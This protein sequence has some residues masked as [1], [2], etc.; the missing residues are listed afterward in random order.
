MSEVAAQILEKSATPPATVDEQVSGASTDAN[1]APAGARPDDK[2]ASKIEVLIRREQMARQR[3]LAAQQKEA[4]LEA[5]LKA[6]EDRFK[7]VDEF[8]SIKTKNPLQALEKLGLTYEDL[9]KIQLSDGEVPPDVQIKKIEE[10]FSQFETAREQ[11]KAQQAETAKKAAAD[12]EEQAIS[13]FKGEIGTY[14]DDNKARYELISF[15]SQQ[16]LVFQVIDEHYRRTIDPETGVGKVMKIEEAA[17]KVEQ[18][19]E[20]KEIKRR[21]V[22]KVKA[23]WS[24]VPKDAIKDAAKQINKPVQQPRTLTNNLSAN[25]TARKSTAPITDQ[26]RVQRAIAYAREKGLA[27]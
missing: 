20:E 13:S 25:Q 3:E 22:S 15:E 8:E 18:F 21:S 1:P 24:A 2:V 14:L 19:L 17:D 7:K 16:D 5:K 10:K 12:R 23:L 11:E 26:E 4:D 27:T 9:T 6:F